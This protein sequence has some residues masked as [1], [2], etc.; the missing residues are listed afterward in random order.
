[1]RLAL[2]VV[3][4]AG[5]RPPLPLPHVEAAPLFSLSLKHAHN[6]Y[7]HRRPLL[8]ALEAKFESVEADLWLD[9]N[10]VAVSHLGFPLR[11]SLK[12]LY[13]DPLAARVAVN[14]GSVYGDGKPFFL[15]L[16][17]KDGRQKLQDLL[18]VELARYPFLT[19]FDDEGEL[20]PGAVTVVLLGDDVSKRAMVDRPAPRPYTRDSNRFSNDDAPADGK[21]GYYSLPYSH[22]LEWSGRGPLPPAQREQLENLVQGAHALGRPIRLYANPDTAEY[23]QAAKAANVDFLNT[24]KLRE[25][26]AAFAP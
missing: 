10:T 5:C 21:W 17:F 6:D 13:L 2:L 24:D 26:S 12:D 18:A 22:F 1:M 7:E 25:L 9:G 19:R 8:D 23:W 4:L 11:G 15:W 3:V 16:E 14:H 20:A